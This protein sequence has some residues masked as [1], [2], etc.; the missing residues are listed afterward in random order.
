MRSRRERA[1][2]ARAPPLA[3]PPQRDPRPL[4]AARRRRRELERRRAARRGAGGGEGIQA[5]RAGRARLAP[6]RRPSVAAAGRDLAGRDGRGRLP[7]RRDAAGGVRRRRRAGRRTRAAPADR[8]SGG[9]R[10]LAAPY[11]AALGFEIDGIDTRAPDRRRAALRRRRA[12][13]LVAG[14]AWDARRRA[15]LLPAAPSA[16]GYPCPRDDRRRH[17]GA[18]V[19]ERVAARGVAI[20]RS[21]RSPQSARSRCWRWRRSADAEARA[22]AQ[23]ALADF[24]LGRLHRH[25]RDGAR[26]RLRGRLALRLALGRVSSGSGASSGKTDSWASPASSRSN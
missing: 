15:R 22:D 4:R 7:R 21:A 3:A 13:L 24:R 12:R 9:D 5:P 1:R 25:A 2:R 26:R 20:D 18:R 16:A 23:L 19:V 17:G 8:D 10:L 6:A 11:G 14:A